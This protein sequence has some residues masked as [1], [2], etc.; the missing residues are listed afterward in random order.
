MSDSISHL[1]NTAPNLGG[2]VEARL[3]YAAYA[4]KPLNLLI[5]AGAALL[6]AILLWQL[7]SATEMTLWTAALLADVALGCLEYTAFQRAAPQPPAIAR[8]RNIFLAGALVAGAAWALGPCLLIANARGPELTLLVTLLLAVCTVAMISLAEQ[9]SAMLAFVAAV[10]VPPALV[11]CYSGGA[12]EGLVALALV[13]GTALI[14]LVGYRLNQTMRKLLE[15]Q[16][17]TRAILDTALDAI[18][19]IDAQGRITDWNRRAE[20]IFGW[21]KGEAQGRLLDETILAP[22]QRDAFRGSLVNAVP[23]QALNQRIERLALRQDGSEFPVEM[24]LTPLQSGLAGHFTVFI[25]DIT[26]RK[27]AQAR[28]SDSEER[29]RT[30]IEWTRE[31][32]AVHRNGLLIYVNPAAIAMFGASSAQDLLGRPVLDFVH[33]DFLPAVLARMKNTPADQVV[34]PLVE[35]KFVKLD[36]SAMD[37]EIQATRISYAGAPAVQVAMRDVTEHKRNVVKLAL[38]NKRLEALIEAIPDTIFF[39]DPESR[40]QIT[41][42]P[43]KR[44]FRLHGLA[45]QDKTELELAQLHPEFRAAHEACL[46]DDEK[47]WQAGRLSLFFETMMDE[48]G[49]AHEFEVRKMPVF[50]EQGQRQALVI[51]GRDITERRQAE[52]AQRIAATAF[53]SQQGMMITNAQRQILRVNK[54]FTAI[55]GYEA[56]ESVGQTPH[57]LASGRHD[58][59]FFAAMWAT[60]ARNGSWQGEIWN[61]RKNGDL[62]PA[63]FTISAVTDDAGQTSHYVGAFTDL[64]SRKT[65]E[66]QIRNLAFYDTLTGL[67]NRRLLMDHLEQA[68]LGSG[69][70]LRKGALLFVDID[71]FKT[72]NDT[73]GHSQGDLL[74]QQVARRLSN[75][76]REGD[77]VARLSGDEFV[78]L[79]ENLSRNDRA[80]AR[81]AETVGEKVL[82]AL[83]QPYQLDH[84]EHHCTS[85]VGI[86]LLSSQ[87]QGST[88]EPLKRAELAMYQAKAAGRNTLRFFDPQMQAEVTTRASLEADLREAVLKDQFVLYYQPQVVGKDR[89][90]GVEALLRWQHPERGLVL[91]AEFIP[92]AEESD[93]ILS[94]GQWVLET[95]CAQLKRW[96][97]QPTLAQLSIAVNVSARQFH[98]EDFVNQVL[99]VLERSGAN[100]KLLKLEL[101]ESL[102][103]DDVEGVI[104]K[105][106]ILKTRGVGFS[107]DDFGTGYSS[108]SYLKRLPL[109]QLKID[110]G[111]VRNILTDPNDAAIA[112]MVIALADS[113]GLAV[114]AEGVEIEAQ[115]DFLAHQGCHAYQGYLF[116]RPLPIDEF[117]AFARAATLPS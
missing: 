110:Q 112:K 16:G 4:R 57:L 44:L 33:P 76:T 77:T 106:S 17:R 50:D 20:T 19:E 48:G 37:V 23:E 111:F 78:V 49:A 87:Q 58:A 21:R 101:T 9:R 2:D 74:L 94:L 91:P 6:I 8:W 72:L 90:T 62:F 107:L 92:L 59:D 46:V 26:E 12:K 113:M 24:S 42:E 45:W 51:I 43:A 86:T 84:G 70:P 55:T 89:L 108:L 27:L 60:I 117:E 75:C 97:S 81:Q 109:D 66:D 34:A 69:R 15:N 22:Q 67:P 47:A 25:A 1:R 88:D 73:L 68:L 83:H 52:Q 38:T 39:K 10:A 96:A 29:F 64:S 3:L 18:I 11:L 102:L 40:W 7:F 114:L 28:I 32:I 65:A 95:A 98:R 82:L 80:A 31:A 85:S 104:A 36:G 53:D 5:T 56:A 54:A 103:V 14:M 30:L 100:P 115:R 35:Q 105:M 93:L 41:N 116:S 61:R 79:L 71:N 13:C 99:T 63:W